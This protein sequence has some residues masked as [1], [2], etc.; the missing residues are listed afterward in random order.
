MEEEELY[1]KIERY[2]Q[3]DMT[4]GERAAFENEAANNPEL[5]EQIALHTVIHAM[6]DEN[7]WLEFDGDPE[8]LKKEVAQFRAKETQEFA[9]KL[10]QFRNDTSIEN[11]QRRPWLS[12]SLI[13]AIAA[14]LI[15]AIFVF[16]PKDPSLES[17]YNDYS[18]W[19]ELPSMSTKG[20]N[21]DTLKELEMRFREKNY[22]GV[23]LLADGLSLSLNDTPQALLYVGAAHLEMAQYDQAIASFDRVIEGNSL[24]F[25]KGYWYKALVF[26]K[27]RDKEKTIEALEVIV[28]NPTY[29]RND[30]AI[31]LLKKLR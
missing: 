22:E 30:E 27:Q 24:D 3:G 2:V 14:V 11:P 31:V 8:L 16:Y 5:K 25:H 6:D 12:K 29:F 10:K 9:Q 21:V 15:I 28:E 18:S 20:D 1:I 26:L 23:I 19:E 4:E 7:S 17:L 13:G